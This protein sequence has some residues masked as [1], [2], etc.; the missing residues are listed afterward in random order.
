MADR[1]E[2]LTHALKFNPNTHKEYLNRLVSIDS[3][4][5]FMSY[6]KITRLN[7]AEETVETE[8]GLREWQLK[9]K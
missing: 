1:I 4:D 7:C 6:K 5:W 9:I 2:K 8:I 3:E